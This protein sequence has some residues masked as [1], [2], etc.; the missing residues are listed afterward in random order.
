[1]QRGLKTQ[2]LFVSWT[3]I[4]GCLQLFLLWVN[5][6][7]F[8]IAW[9]DTVISVTIVSIIAQIIYLIQSH[10]HSERPITSIHFAR[11][12]TLTFFYQLSTNSI[13]R[14][15]VGKSVWEQQIFP[16]AV[17]RAIIVF[18]LL[19]IISLYWWIEKNNRIQEQIQQQLIAKE[20][21]L[22]RAELNNIH[23]QLQPHFLF[24]SLNSISSLTL[25]SPKEA[26]R[27]IQLLSD[28]LRG[29]LRK[30]IQQ[31][32]SLTDE[33]NQ[34]K[35]Y[36]EI[37]KIRFGHRLD[38]QLTQ[39]EACTN[40]KVPALII[41]PLIEN[42]L[43]YGLYGTTEK[44]TLSIDLKCDENTLLITVKNP[45]DAEF[46]PQQQGIGFGHASIQRRL[47]LFYGQNELLKTHASL[48]EYTC[49]LRIPQQ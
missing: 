39:T 30:D 28:F 43:K 35:L 18:L 36:L 7:P 48:T 2:L 10:Y 4:A 24:N 44:S 37:E 46:A 3:F 19:T 11:I 40:A 9:K 8:E 21:A 16:Y 26:N 49:T 20:R 14:W 41:Q 42:A 47:S 38:I 12:L 17:L 27:M 15:W 23:Q 1:V 33:L 31:L 22:T 45:Y 34:L 29:T 25:I 6:F 5:Q 13:L 32:V